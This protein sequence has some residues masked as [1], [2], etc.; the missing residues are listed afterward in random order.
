MN[1]I[2][3]LPTDTTP[4]LW[5]VHCAAIDQVLAMAS[6]EAATNWA[7]SAN[8][9]WEQ[10][11]KARQVDT[12]PLG[13]KVIQSPWIGEEHL[14]QCVQILSRFLADC[15]QSNHALVQA[16]NTLAQNSQRHEFHRLMSIDTVRRDA[17]EEV[18][19]DIMKDAKDPETETEFDELLDQCIAKAH[20]AGLWPVQAEAA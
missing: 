20:E 16:C 4:Q 13:A 9:N 5:A 2:A 3:T 14:R 6:F 18:T 15:E 17:V 12:P 11:A 19:L 7:A 1:N 10:Q 8:A